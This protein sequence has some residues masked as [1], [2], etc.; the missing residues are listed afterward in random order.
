MD[1]SRP[2]K[3]PSV[4]LFMSG[5]STYSLLMRCSTSVY[6]PSWGYGR[7]VEALRPRT[8]PRTSSTMR[9]AEVV[10]TKYL[11]RLFIYFQMRRETTNHYSARAPNDWTMLGTFWLLSAG[12]NA[13]HARVCFRVH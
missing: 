8:P 4:T 9:H 12:I 1:S 6:T 2:F 10:T 13:V 3:A 7:S 11:I 5:S